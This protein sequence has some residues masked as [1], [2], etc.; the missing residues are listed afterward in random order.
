[1]FA[2]CSALVVLF[3]VGLACSNNRAADAKPA[4]PEFVGVWVASDGSTITIRSDSSA[5]YKIGGSSVSGGKAEV[6]EKDKTLRIGLLGMGSPMKLDK[7]P[8]NGE[9]T[10]DGIVYKKGGGRSISQSN[11]APTSVPIP[12]EDKLQS[13]AKATMMD[14]NDAVTNDDF[15]TFH[16]KTAKPLQDSGTPDEMKSEFQSFVDQK[17][18]FY[19]R[20][21]LKDVN[22]KFSPAPSMGKVEEFDV[23]TLEGYYPTTPSKLGF[24]LKYVQEDGAWKLFGINIK[25]DK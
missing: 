8:A 24:K 3:A 17:E 6:S 18:K 19:L 7:A 16:G 25:T 13:L 11:Q 5:D 4:G 14:F 15:A 2:A 21:A 20:Q 23:L 22:A 10:V 9:M 12:S 1:M